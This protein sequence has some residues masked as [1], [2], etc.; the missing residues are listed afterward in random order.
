M[1]AEPLGGEVGQVHDVATGRQVGEAGL[2][3]DVPEDVVILVGAGGAAV[4]AAGGVPP[5]LRRLQV[6]RAGHTPAQQP[7]AVQRPPGVHLFF[8][9]KKK[10]E[11]E[12]PLHNFLLKK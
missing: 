5:C 4:G 8:N 7:V 3:E 11:D 12:K 10:N 2:L 9:N 1:V 6:Q